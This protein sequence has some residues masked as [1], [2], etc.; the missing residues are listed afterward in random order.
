M[1]SNKSFVSKL[2]LRD[3]KKRP[4]VIKYKDSLGGNILCLQETQW[5]KNDLSLIKI[6]GKE[7]DF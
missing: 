5:A 1:S 7:I 6:F 4:D 2:S 3:F